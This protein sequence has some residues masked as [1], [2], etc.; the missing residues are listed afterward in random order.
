MAATGPVPV[1]ALSG[2]TVAFPGLPAVVDD[3]SFTVGGGERVA[4]VGESGSGKTLTALAA[5][6]A[7]PEPAQ[8]VAGT[9]AVDRRGGGPPGFVMQEAASALNPGL[10]VGGQRGVCLPAG[11]R[12]GRAARATAAALLTRVGLEPELLDAY[13][14]QL[15][16][17][18]AQRAMIAVALAGRPSLI[19]ADEPTTGLD[20]VTQAHVL[21][22]F[23]R[24]SDD[25]GLALLLISHDLPVVAC[26]VHRVVVLFAGQVVESAPAAALFA[27]PLHPYTQL[28]VASRLDRPATPP[29]GG[30]AATGDGCRFV[31]RCPQ[32]VT[33]CSTAPPPLV[34]L[35]PEH[36]VRCPPA[37]AATTRG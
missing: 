35:D 32:A 14:H 17:G 7:L 18:Q 20:L 29:A 27:R 30:V 13:P 12:R 5:V 15:S 25:D 26:L 21:A 23:R 2:L 8:M 1:L 36:A 22:L 11:E 3:V 24:L 33:A 10:T 37:A 28:L 19:V 31:S 4:L 9:V 6:G 34:A 16:G